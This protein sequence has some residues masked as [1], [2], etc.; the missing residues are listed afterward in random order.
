MKRLY[1]RAV[2]VAAPLVAL[3]FAAYLLFTDPSDS[4]Y[5]CPATTWTL[6]TQAA[7]AGPGSE[8]FFDA[9]AACNSA[10]GDRAR[11]ASAVMLFTLSLL[12]VTAAADVA[13]TRRVKQ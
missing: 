1:M 2:T 12:L 5:D 3:L 7:P 4:S 6:L 10:A 13:V 8:D 9:G 11:T